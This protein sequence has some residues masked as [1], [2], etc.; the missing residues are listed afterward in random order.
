M[1]IHRLEGG[2]ILENEADVDFR[3]REFRA[4]LTETSH[5]VADLLGVFHADLGLGFGLD[6][7]LDMDVV[8]M[9]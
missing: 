3:S 6:D 1:N 7:R 9:C 4:E 5:E 2:L 8:S